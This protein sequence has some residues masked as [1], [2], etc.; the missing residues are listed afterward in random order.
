MTYTDASEIIAMVEARRYD[1]HADLAN[2][3]QFRLIRNE[4]RMKFE[5][6]DQREK[7]S[8][9]GWTASLVLVMS[10][11]VVAFI[12]SREFTSAQEAADIVEQDELAE[13]VEPTFEDKWSEDAQAALETARKV[14]KDLL[15]FFTGSDWC[16]PCKLLNDEVFSQEDFQFEASRHFV[17]VKLDF[18][19]DTPQTEKLKAQNKEMA[20]R[21]GVESYPTVVLMDINS[22][23]YAITGYQEGGVANYLGALEEFRQL[24]IKRD[25]KLAE[26]KTATG[27]DRAKLLDEA[28]AGLDELVISVYYEDIVA[29][30]V[31]LDKED[32]AG[33]RSKWNAQ[34]ES[35]MRK[36]VMTDI[37]MISRLEKPEKAIQ[38]IDDVLK[39]LR[40]PPDER[41]SVLQ[42]KLNLV[43]KLDDPQRLDDLLDEMINLEGAETETRERL[44]V[45]KILLMIGSGRKQAAIKLLDN[46]IVEG[47]DNMH[48]LRV[49]GDILEADEKYEEAVKAYDLAIKAASNAPD[50]LVEVV[51]AKA[52][53][54]YEMKEVKLAL[55]TLDNFADDANMPTDLRSAT[56]LHKALM[57]RDSDRRRQARLAE[58]RAIE[59]A[60]SPKQRAEIEKLVQRLRAKYDQ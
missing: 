9:S 28:I 2:D 41:I 35:E 17:L 53:V 4:T 37:L 3:E 31:E 34:K 26:A 30:I 52:D 45:K 21:Y 32:E 40:F 23:P 20:S 39:E 50:M 14:D 13:A 15:L 46:S 55:Q 56:L 51:G 57:M 24:R 47:Q 49:K 25:E 48:L 59:I 38:F 7:S 1:T 16:P 42:I 60:E 18:P 22:K 43:R 54:L 27:L 19:K 36:I 33:L 10:F 29:E 58:N 5:S 8:T 12:G 6:R 11:V 44:I